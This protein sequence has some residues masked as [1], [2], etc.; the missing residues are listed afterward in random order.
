MPRAWSFPSN[1]QFSPI[2]AQMV[3]IVNFQK[4]NKKKHRTTSSN[5]LY[6]DQSFISSEAG[7]S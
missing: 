1:L 2:S 3:H 5:I 7:Y 4:K 6:D